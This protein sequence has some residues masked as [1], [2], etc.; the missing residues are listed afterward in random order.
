MNAPG[1]SLGTS[2]ET[3]RRGKLRFSKLATYLMKEFQNGFI[4]FKVNVNLIDLVFSAYSD[5]SV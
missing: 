5:F 2:K 3:E 4:Q 1:P